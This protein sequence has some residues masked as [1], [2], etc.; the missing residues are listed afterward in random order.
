MD[1][2]NKKEKAPFGAFSYV[3]FL[4]FFS[5]VYRKEGQV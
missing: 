5:I 2:N 1:L 4:I 3:S